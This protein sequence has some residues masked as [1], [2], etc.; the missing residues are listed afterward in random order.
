[1]KDMARD[2]VLHIIADQQA[3][4]RQ[5]LVVTPTMP[6]VPLEKLA[7]PTVE[8]ISGTINNEQYVTY[9]LDDFTTIS[10]GIVKV[11]EGKGT[12]REMR[13]KT[14]TEFTDFRLFIDNVLYFRGN[15][16]L[17]EERG[18][19]FYDPHDGTYNIDIYTLKFNTSLTIQID[20]GMQVTDFLL[21]YTSPTVTG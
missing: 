14:P 2:I 13:L 19:A 11:I 21:V 20:A 7:P 4:A 16:T 17:T 12:V 3:T 9:S 6:S 5:R 8:H 18:L 10:S 1:M 15:F